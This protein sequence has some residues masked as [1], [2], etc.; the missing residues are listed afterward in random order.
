MPTLVLQA[1][2]GTLRR[3]RACLGEARLRRPVLELRL[4]LRGALLDRQLRLRHTVRLSM[5]RRQC[6]ARLCGET[7]LACHW[8]EGAKLIW[9]TQ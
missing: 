6:N 8:W 4:E 5:H 7:P 1:W 9:L 3:R 2:T